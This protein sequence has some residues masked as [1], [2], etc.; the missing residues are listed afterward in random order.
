MILNNYTRLFSVLETS[1]KKRFA[2]FG[3]FLIIIMFLETFSLGM[4]YPFLQSITNN[5]LNNEFS[6]FFKSFNNALKID[7]N[8]ELTALLIF[9]IA[10]VLKNFFLYFFEYW[11][12][13]LL[14]D[15]K[16]NFKTKILKTHLSDD[17]EKS[18]NIKTS[19]Y[20]RDFNGTVDTF[21]R[22]L[23]SSMLWIIEF[24]VFLGLVG[25]LIFIQS[26]E[27]IFFVIT[28]GFL[29]IFFVMTLKNIL[30][31][32]GSNIFYLKERSMNKLLDILNSSKEIIMFKKS[33]I[34]TKQF[35]KFE[36]KSLN[37]TRNVNMIQ[38][39]PKIFF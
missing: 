13:T 1:Q 34:F 20:I 33:S 25:L 18:S 6:N 4:F 12:L 27:T 14:R 19:V 39:F 36:F 15:L 10:I 2:Y 8:I 37:I 31:N 7:L 38:K 3:F 35:I 30:K 29:A 32:F 11:S 21:I 16:L 5:S 17:Y 24:G 28:I 26:K 23:Q 22:S 9:T